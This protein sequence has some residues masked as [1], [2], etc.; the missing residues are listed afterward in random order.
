MK[1]KIF[2]PILDEDKECYYLSIPDCANISEIKVLK[3][4]YTNIK[5]NRDK[6]VYVESNRVSKKMLDNLAKS[7]KKTVNS[8]YH[9]LSNQ[10]VD[11]QK[12]V[13]RH[14]YLTASKDNQILTL[15][16]KDTKKE[17]NAI[18]HNCFVGLN[19][20]KSAE[21][22]LNAIMTLVEYCVKNV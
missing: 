6:I 11:P 21:C 19:A 16:V 12:T 9:R 22:M 15:Y 4:Y 7:I 17:A 3:G 1:E 14:F 13:I 8:H 20:K 18:Q 2:N 5:N 10:I